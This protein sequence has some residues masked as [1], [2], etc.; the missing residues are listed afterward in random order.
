MHQDTYESKLVEID[1]SIRQ[2]IIES[3][4]QVQDIQQKCNELKEKVRN[5]ECRSRRDKLRVDGRREYEEESW[6]DT[7][8]LLKG[9]LQEKLGVNDIQ[10]ERAHRAGPKQ[11]GKDR[12]IIAKLSSYKGKQHALNEARC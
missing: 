5:L 4:S 12:T 3:I 8:G 7:E 2:E 10:I 6:D 9:I 11:A 1:N